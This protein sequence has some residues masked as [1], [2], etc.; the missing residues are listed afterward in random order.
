ML[1][2]E[3]QPIDLEH[4]QAITDL[5]DTYGYGDSA[6]AFKT[7]YI[8]KKDMSLSLCQA[9]GMYAVKME[10]EGDNT[11]FF[12]VGTDAEKCE[13]I[14]EALSRGNLVFR[15]MTRWDTYF[16]QQYF[17]GKFVTDPAPDDSEYVYDRNTIENLPGGSF[18]RK[19]DYVR[20]LVRDHDMETRFLSKDIIDDV[21]QI[22]EAW[23]KS[24]ENY[25]DV[26]DK[27][28]AQIILS[29]HEDLDISGVVLYM[30]DAPCAAVLGYRLGDNTVDCCFQKTDSYL[31][32]LQYYMRQEFSKMQPP[33]VEFFNWEEDLGIQGLRTAKQYMH[34][35]SMIDMFTGRLI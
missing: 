5:Y 25:T 29:E 17:P 23:E 19:R 18:S 12:P 27:N 15:Y 21:Q 14:S 24:K 1:Q 31:H 10:N 28:A 11:W 20:Q 2:I 26:L 4:Q 32:G 30:D 22:L 6:H 9:S 33:G 8:W 34:P 7:L 13:F 3:L 35:C 16:L